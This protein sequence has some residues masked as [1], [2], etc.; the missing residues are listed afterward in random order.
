[1]DFPS[2]TYPPLNTICPW[3]VESLGGSIP[4]AALMSSLTAVATSAANQAFYFPFFLYEQA[5]AVKLS[6]WNGSV[7]A[8]NV[9]MGIYDSQLNR[10][11]N[12]GSTAQ[13]TISVLQTVDITDTALLPGRYWMAVQFSDV[14]ATINTVQNTDEVFQSTIPA[15]EQAVGSFGLPTT[16]TLAQSTAGNPRLMALAVHF[17]TLV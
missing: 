10:V 5:T 9:D 6:W 1:M 14:T 8:G 13:G 12:T 3:S 11:I 2:L 16:A 15:W 17:S 7:S 4:R